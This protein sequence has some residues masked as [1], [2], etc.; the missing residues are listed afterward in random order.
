VQPERFPRVCSGAARPPRK[1][2]GTLHNRPLHVVEEAANGV[3]RLQVK[4]QRGGR[5]CAPILALLCQCRRLRRLP[6]TASQ[7]PTSVPRSSPWWT[8]ITSGRCV[9]STWPSPST[10]RSKSENPVASPRATL[11]VST[12]AS[13]PAAINW[14]A[15][16][17]PLRPARRT[18]QPLRN[19]GAPPG[20]K[21]APDF[22]FSSRACRFSIRRNRGSARTGEPL[23]RKNGPAPRISA[24]SEAV[25]VCSAA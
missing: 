9:A 1:L 17:A 11:P 20:D 5:G 16:P 13:A 23:Q 24:R 4:Q 7:R 12:T 2:A 25:P 15:F 6:R 3:A 22:R 10:I 8:S 21:T 19:Y 14:P 18:A